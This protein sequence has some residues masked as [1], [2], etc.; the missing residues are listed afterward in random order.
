MRAEAGQGTGAR[1]WAGCELGQPR[2]PGPINWTLV[3]P[4]QESQ[5]SPDIRG[6][7]RAG[8]GLTRRVGGLLG[9][10]GRLSGTVSPFRAEQGT[11]LVKAQHEGALP[12]PCIVRK[13]PR[14]WGRIKGAK[15]RFAFQD[16]TWDIF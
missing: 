7:S 12:P 6:H 9:V 13:D 2:G 16:G 1:C 5:C 15:Y 10:A 14:F 4:G 11:S 3:H 8:L